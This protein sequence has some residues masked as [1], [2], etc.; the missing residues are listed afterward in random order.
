[1]AHER[2]TMPAKRT[3]RGT[4]RRTRVRVVDAVAVLDYEAAL[5]GVALRLAEVF[6]RCDSEREMPALALRLVQVMEDLRDFTDS[7]SPAERPRGG[8]DEL[9]TRRAAVMS[10]ASME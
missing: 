7:D 2:V 6:D 4:G 10:A 9:A 5:R 8:A 3:T 1:M